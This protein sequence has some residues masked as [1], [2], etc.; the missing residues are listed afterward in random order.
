[1]E[2]RRADAL[3]PKAGVLTL[4]PRKRITGGAVAL[5][6]GGGDSLPLSTRYDC[7]RL[8]RNVVVVIACSSRSAG[9]GHAGS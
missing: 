7:T 1:M 3:S 4:R 2:G 9:H 5:A 8:T 6:T